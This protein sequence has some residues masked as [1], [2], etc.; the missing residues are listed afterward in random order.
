MSNYFSILFVFY[1]YF[2]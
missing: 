2:N 1:I